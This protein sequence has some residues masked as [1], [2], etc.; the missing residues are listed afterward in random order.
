M[1]WSTAPVKVSFELQALEVQFYIE[2]GKL[3]EH[4]EDYIDL[5]L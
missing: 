2:D 4:F 1:Q 5:R 3:V